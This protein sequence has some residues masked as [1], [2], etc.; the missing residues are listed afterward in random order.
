[1]SNLYFTSDQHFGHNNVIKF[2]NRP[3]TPETMT[4]ELI[5]RHN[6]VVSQGARVYHLGD[7]FWRTITA[8]AANTIL[9]QLNGQHYFIWGNHDET[10]EELLK[11]QPDAF[12]WAKDTYVVGK[13]SNHPRIILSHYSHQVWRGSH[14][15]DWHLFGHTHGALKGIG[16]SFDVGVDCW[17]YFPVSIEQVIEKMAKL[18]VFS[19]AAGDLEG[20]IRGEDANGARTVSKTV[21]AGSTPATPAILDMGFVK[22]NY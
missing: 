2:C 14:R 20:H 10:V 1:M 4:R 8:M 3:F 21:E 15:G 11:W 19:V 12:V 16:K 9:K 5:E 18:E 22:R 13:E 6:S 17:N 7:I